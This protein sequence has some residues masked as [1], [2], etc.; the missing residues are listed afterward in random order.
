MTPMVS[1]PRSLACGE[2]SSL[3][4]DQKSLIRSMSIIGV[5]LGILIVAYALGATENPCAEMTG[6]EKQNCEDL[7]YG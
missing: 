6:T 5:I 3:S 1:R 7:V 4:E 2:G